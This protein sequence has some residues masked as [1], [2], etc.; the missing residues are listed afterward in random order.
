MVDDVIVDNGDIPY[1]HIAKN[2]RR[3]IKNA[4]S[5][6]NIPLHPEVIRLNFLAY[7]KEIKALGYKLL[8]PDL[9]SPTSS[10]PLGDRFYK[11]FKPILVAAGVTEKGLG[12]PRGA[13]SVRSTIEEEAGRCGGPRR[14]ARP[15]W[16]HGNERA[17]LRASR[18]RYV[19]EI[20]DGAA[21]DHC[22][23]AAAGNQSHS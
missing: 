2:E 1:L 11:Q 17:L 21:R 9:F 15:R 3:R 20:R 13:S 22:R 7:V 12:F 19:A 4:Q 5:Q 16:R 8:F 10:S 6:R 23:S 14:F 18:D